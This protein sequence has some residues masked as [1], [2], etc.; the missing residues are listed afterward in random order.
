MSATFHQA[1]LQLVNARLQ[2]LPSVPASSVYVE[3]V[4]A[5][6]R[7]ECPA[8]NLLPG[9]T[10]FESI[11]ADGDWDLL[12]ATCAFT[13]KVHTRGDPHTQLA[14]PVIADA[15]TAVMADPTLGGFAMRLRVVSSRPQ[16]APADGTAGIYELGYEV[17]LAVSEQNLALQQ[18]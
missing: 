12:R 14:D 8:I 4:A 17:T 16:Q 18:V 13:L 11:G 6:D 2:A 15:H 7:E 1:L 3:R 5:I 10:R 9:D